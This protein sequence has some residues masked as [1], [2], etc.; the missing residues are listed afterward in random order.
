MQ[1]KYLFFPIVVLIS[2]ALFFGFIW[3][4]ISNL[5]LANKDGAEKRSEL[6]ALK[7]KQ[8]KIGEIESKLNSD[9]GSDNII[10]SYLPENKTEER[11]IN[12]IN[13][14]AGG[15]NVSLMDISMI[16]TKSSAVVGDALDAAPNYAAAAAAI[17]I[18]TSN[19][20]N[21]VA[22]AGSLVQQ[23]PIK[24]SL[25]GDYEKVKI[26]L[27]SLQRMSVF[28]V[29]NSVSIVKQKA[30]KKT[31]TDGVTTEEKSSSNLM[32][33]VE[34]DFGYMKISKINNSEV[35]KLETSLDNNSITGL[36]KYISQ[37]SQTINEDGGIGVTGVKGKINPFFAN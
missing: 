9:V 1:L 22:T 18:P 3:P 29:I 34:V 25:I 5:Q 20:Q 17:G 30:E 16:G 24:I 28:N 35:D 19:G 6:Q 4:E 12:E 8:V 23:M 33:N 27:D 21:T 13:Y 36:K 31:A 7:E 32:V 11:V 15:A 14:L 26:F 10:L 37:K 2:V